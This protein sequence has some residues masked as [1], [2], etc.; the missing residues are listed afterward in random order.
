MRVL[1]VG[2]KIILVTKVTIFDYVV[3]HAMAANFLTNVI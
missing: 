1:S 2:L 3:I